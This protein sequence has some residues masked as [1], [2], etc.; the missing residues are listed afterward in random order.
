MRLVIHA[1][2]NSCQLKDLLA[3]V[4]SWLS[5]PGR[6]N[7]LDCR[8]G[9]LLPAE[10][11]THYSDVIMGTMA[12]Q[13]TSLAIVYPIVLSSA[14]QRKYQSPVSLGFVRGIHRSPVNSPHKW[15]VTRKMFSF[16]DVIMVDGQGYTA[17]TGFPWWMIFKMKY[18][19]YSKISMSGVL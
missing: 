2:I 13:I 14:D 19:A 17:M 18:V 3:L 5:Q 9:S 4:N 10:G 1:A 8:Q 7:E 12:F 15:P 11:R 6:P 16:D